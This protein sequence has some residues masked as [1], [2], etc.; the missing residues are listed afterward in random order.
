MQNFSDIHKFLNNISKLKTD[1]LNFD[2]LIFSK[3]NLRA[4]NDTGNLINIDKS[5]INWLN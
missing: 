3:I 1:P 5:K 2:D 4:V